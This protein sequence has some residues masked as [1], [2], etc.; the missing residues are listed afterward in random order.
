MLLWPALTMGPSPVAQP[1]S[2]CSSK[3]HRT[4][5]RASWVCN[6]AMLSVLQLARGVV[7]PPLACVETSEVSDGTACACSPK[8]A[9]WQAVALATVLLLGQ[10]ALTSRQM[11]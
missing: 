3:L 8:H 9:P 10:A 7:Q 6:Q 11:H 2:A 5:N 1:G 4:S